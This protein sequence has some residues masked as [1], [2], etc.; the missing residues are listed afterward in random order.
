MMIHSDDEKPLVYE[1]PGIAELNDFKREMER[2]RR[3]TH[4][5]DAVRSRLATRMFLLIAVL[6]ILL[7]VGVIAGRLNIEQA[8]DLGLAALTPVVAVFSGI[9]GFFFGSE[10][11]NR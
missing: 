10:S 1:E 2:H 3:N 11:G 9:V 8:K 7:V 4:H 5:R 6:A